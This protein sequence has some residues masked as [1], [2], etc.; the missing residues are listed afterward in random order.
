M[1]HIHFYTFGLIII[2]LIGFS[3]CEKDN[4][5]IEPI[6][7]FEIQL[8]DSIAPANVIFLNKSVNLKHFEWDFGEGALSH[9][10]S[11][12]HFFDVDGEY[13]VTLRAW[14]DE[15]MIF[16]QKTFSLLK[17]Y[18]F[19]ILNKSSFILHNLSAYTEDANKNKA[20][21]PIGTLNNSDSS[22][23]CYSSCNSI[24]IYF[25]NNEGVK[26]KSAFPFYLEENII[27]QL[28]VDN[29]TLIICE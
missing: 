2:I 21:I 25:E 19:I 9:D 1:K 14:N 24:Y 22:E 13:T 7:D 6:L 4:G 11:P 5:F 20:V 27:N 16:I 29:H 18:R 12:E 17:E 23:R 15:K 8:T 3:S 28:I 26:F 10:E